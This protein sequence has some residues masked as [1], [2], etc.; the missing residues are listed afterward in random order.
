[1]REDQVTVVAEYTE[2]NMSADQSIK[3]D[4]AWK[5]F[6][7]TAII[8]FVVRKNVRSLFESIVT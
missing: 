1:M 5:V 8:S 4:S 7:K 2:R 3:K 6:I